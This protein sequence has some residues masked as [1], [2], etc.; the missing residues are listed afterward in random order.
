M[1]DRYEDSLFHP[2]DPEAVG[3]IARVYLTSADVRIHSMGSFHL[4][5]RMWR[6]V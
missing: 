5:E 6:I 3:N 2:P 1:L 4:G